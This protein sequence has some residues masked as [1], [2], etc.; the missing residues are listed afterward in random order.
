M[1]K[2]TIRLDY[3]SNP[4]L[5]EALSRRAIGDK[6]TLEIDCTLSER[7]ET[8][9]LGT[10]TAVTIEDEDGEEKTVEPTG[11]APVMAMVSA[12][13]PAASE[14]MGMHEMP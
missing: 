14:M 10:I 11:D 5:T 9:I 7:T 2:N 13:K 3:A 12:P 1:P 8:S 6:L 4:D